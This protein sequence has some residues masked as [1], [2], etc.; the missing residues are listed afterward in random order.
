MSRI[1]RAV[2]NPT[3]PV[4]SELMNAVDAMPVATERRGTVQ[5]ISA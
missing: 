3:V 2:D 5:V 4:L 1:V